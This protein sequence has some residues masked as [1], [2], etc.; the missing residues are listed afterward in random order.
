MGLAMPDHKFDREIDR[1]IIPLDLKQR[2]LDFMDFSATPPETG[3]YDEPVRYFKA[4]LEWCKFIFGLLAWAEHIAYWKDAE[5]DLH[6]AIQQILIF[7]EGI[8]GG[9]LMSPE[10]FE[11]G[12]SNGIY[13]AFN[14]LAAQIKSGVKGGFTVNPDGTVSYPT[15]GGGGAP[16]PDDPTTPIDESLAANAGRAIAAADGIQLLLNYCDDWFNGVPGVPLAQAQTRLK[17]LFQLNEAEADAFLAYYYAGEPS[18]VMTLES[19]LDSMFFCRGLTVSTFATYV[20]NEHSPL[21]EV[22][23]LEMLIPAL[24]QAQ[25][26][27]WASQGLPTSLYRTY[28]CTPIATE[29]FELD[30]STSNN[31]LYTTSGIWKGLHR[32]L[33]EVEGSFTDSDNPDLV[34]DAIYFHN[35]V[36]GVKTYSPMAIAVA[37]G[38]LS[39]LTQAQVPF[40]ADHKYSFTVDFL[41][42]GGLQA[43]TFGRANG[44]MNLPNVLGTLSIRVTDLGEYAVE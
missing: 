5:D 27:L 36:S 44:D 19:V 13:K 8:E 25:L 2:I 3:I 39:G 12:I 18:A 29:E 7:E 9:I 10:D 21:I 37:I 28:P 34:G 31:P 43:A 22:P 23:F 42:A 40:A 6:H 11:N 35:L 41:S 32:F 33:I 26:D 16:V 30:M 14:D 4:N 24:T 15:T 1:Q 20:W 38:S 17:T